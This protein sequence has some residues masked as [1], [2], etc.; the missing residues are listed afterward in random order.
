MTDIHK[1]QMSI[2]TIIVNYR[3]GQMVLDH[4]E[5]ILTDMRTVAGSHLFIVD[6]DSPNGDAALLKDGIDGID[7]VTLI[8]APNN[9]GF[10]YGNNRALE[11]ILPDP[12]F[13]AV[14]FLNPDAY[15]L[16]GCYQ[17]MKNF[18]AAH[19]DAGVIGTRLEFEDGKPQ[20]SAFR[21]MSARSE[22]E[23]EA[24]I[25]LITNLFKHQSIYLP[26]TE[27]A[28]QADWVSG[29]S[30]LVTRKALEQVPHMDEEYFL[31]YE[32]VD[33]QYAVKQAGFEVW[34]T[35]AAKAV[36]LCGGSTEVVDGRVHG[37]RPGYWFDSRH[38]YFAKRFSPFHTLIIDLGWITGSALFT[39]KRLL[40]GKPLSHLFS[41]AASIM[42]ARKVQVRR[43]F[44]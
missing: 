27:E 6:N 23:A 3:T 17:A 4:L 22:F 16:P 38:R 34:V 39:L 21:Y 11:I 41:D 32:E 10:A 28:H 33:F 36:H 15:P 13:N 19:P 18:A 7:D 26:V 44:K 20:G 1:A 8:A 25:S 24:Q 2:A 9:G 29:A 43:N 35:P 5:R 31:Y 30:F 40:T 12:R 14:Y 37:K 42:R